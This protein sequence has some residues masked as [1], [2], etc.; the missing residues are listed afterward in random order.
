MSNPGSSVSVNALSI[1]VPAGIFM[2]VTTMILFHVK[3]YIPS[4]FTA[5]LWIGIPMIAFLITTFMNVSSQYMYCHQVDSGKA[6][7]GAV[8]SVFAALIG[9]IVSS[10]SICRIPVV[11]II[12]PLIKKEPESGKPGCCPPQPSLETIESDFPIV[13]GLSYG[14]Y[15]FFSMLFGI[16]FG[17]GIAVVC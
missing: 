12:A 16:V 1:A 13:S 11:S 9:L 14:F 5:V 6:L 10:F 7:L 17:S 15:L 2:F 4:I 3:N 8:P